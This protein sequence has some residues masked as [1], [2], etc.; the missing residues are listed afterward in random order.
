[1]KGGKPVSTA[2]AALHEQPSPREGSGHAP[3]DEVGLVL[4]GPLG[5]PALLPVQVVE[6]LGAA[7]LF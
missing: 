7:L 3:E 2:T 4:L 5:A 6:P 1:M